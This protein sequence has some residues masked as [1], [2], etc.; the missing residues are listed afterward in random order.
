M[1]A[2]DEAKTIFS[3]QA[4]ALAILTGAVDGAKAQELLGSLLKS[5][6]LVR[7]SSY[8][9]FYLFEAF[10]A[11]GR[12]DLI[13]DRLD[14]WREMLKLGFKTTPE[15]PKANTR[16]DCHAWSAQ[17][18]F[19]L[20]ASVAGIRPASPGFR[21]VRIEPQ[22]GSW[23]SLSASMPH[24]GGGLLEVGIGDGE[25]V[26]KLPSGLTGEFVWKGRAR[27]LKPGV[28]TLSLP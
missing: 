28:Q 5:K 6:D 17:I 3:E 21:T 4:Q 27:K 13:Q 19:H 24:A 18:L 11:L 16:S 8:F 23:K 1:V 15:E 25:A 10:R 7:A 2:D 12:V 26:V 9:A 22:L 14:M 20:Y